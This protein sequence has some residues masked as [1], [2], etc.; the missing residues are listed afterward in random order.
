MRGGCD[1]ARS[2]GGVGVWESV[3]VWIDYVGDI[4]LSHENNLTIIS[5]FIT[6]RTT[7]NICEKFVKSLND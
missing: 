3:C 7:Y 1:S 4:S 6:S 5:Y 2:G